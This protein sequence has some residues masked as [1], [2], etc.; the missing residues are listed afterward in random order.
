MNT[1]KGW[2]SNGW[3]LALLGTGVMLGTLGPA[4]GA[5]DAEKVSITLGQMKVVDTPFAV[6]GF[7]VT[8]QEIVKCETVGDRQVRIMGLKVGASDVQ[9]TGEAGA[10]ALYAVTVIE[11]I[12]EVLA[13]M[14]KDLDGVPEVDLSVNRDRVVL[15]GEVS[16]VE[17]WE[18]MQKVLTAYEK[19]YLNLVT[20]RPA[21][22]V[23]MGLKAAL[24]KVGFKVLQDQDPT[25]IGVLGV[26]F[27]GNTVFVNGRVYTPKDL[28]RLAQVVAAQD[29]L[30]L[31][32]EQEKGSVKVPAVLNVSVEPV[33]IEV[34][35]VYVGF[36]DI[37]SKQIGVNLAKQGLIAVDT[38]AAGFAGV[39]GKG[40]G[41]GGNYS[42]NSG[43][44]GVLNF[45]ANNGVKRFRNAG[46]LTFKS[47]DAPQWKLFQS[48]GTLKVK[49]AG[50]STTAG[51]L[52]DIDYGLIMRV[53][54][55][56]SDA[57]VADLEVELELSAPELQKNGDY[58]LKRN[59]VNTSLTCELGKT[60]A[61]GGM[62]DLV[63]NTTGPS[64]V[65]FLRS[66]PVVQWFFSEQED[67]MV[68]SQVLILISAQLA[69]APRPSIPVSQ[70]TM[71][72]ET[73][74]Q[75]NNKERMKE[76]RKGKR[77]FFF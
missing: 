71:D 13:A 28:D 36:N 32:K 22:E 63:Q 69:G 50:T 5:A 65:P 9:V 21:P 74:V 8:D 48:G 57:K 45:M 59:R 3:R 76:D 60:M 6:Q 39:L 41:W 43:M 44:Q 53:R 64:G 1:A 61:I 23:M 20:F 12:K 14:K 52:Q 54:G 55:G 49:I 4:A 56:L 16:S 40:G 33:M 31:K 75:Q 27:S 30:T 73:K 70:E 18:L 77:F 58:D 34:D 29:W 26:K 37:Q 72:T 38:T 24:E 15:K 35:V 46:H 17:H 67:A 11:N 47:N 68:N 19:Q 7:R 66:V 62:K 2:L 42:F 25:Q 10:S 51:A